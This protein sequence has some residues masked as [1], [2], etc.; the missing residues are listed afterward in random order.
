[1]QYQN[2]VWHS[3]QTSIL[4]KARNDFLF[5]RHFAFDIFFEGREIET[6]SLNTLPK[7]SVKFFTKIFFCRR[8]E[9]V[10]QFL[11]ESHANP[12]KDEDHISRP[13][14]YPHNNKIM[15]TFLIEIPFNGEFY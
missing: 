9:I 13:R 2:N 3:Q 12:Q 14:T 8:K 11:A 6:T 7:I 10:L 1:M 15:Y 5:V 4:R